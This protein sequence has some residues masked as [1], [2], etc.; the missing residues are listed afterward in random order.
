[1]DEERRLLERRYQEE[2]DQQRRQLAAATA[3]LGSLA[4]TADKQR[5]SEQELKQQLEDRDRIAAQ[6]P[7]IDY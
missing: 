2:T 1:V 7:C 3:E 5:R 6:V 4:A